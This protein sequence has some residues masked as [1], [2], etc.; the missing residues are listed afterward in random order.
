MRKRRVREEGK[1]KGERENLRRVI[2]ATSFR[3]RESGEAGNINNRGKAEE[4][5]GWKE[6]E[7][8]ERG[9]K[10]QRMI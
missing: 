7:G 5:K 9:E 4:R 10:K 1:G 2:S 8:E 3:V 6:A